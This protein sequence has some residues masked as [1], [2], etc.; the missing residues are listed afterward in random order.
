MGIAGVPP[1]LRTIITVPVILA[2]P[3]TRGD[4]T[5]GWFLHARHQFASAPCASSMFGILSALR[6]AIARPV[7]SQRQC[8]VVDVHASLPISTGCH[9]FGGVRSASTRAPSGTRSSASTSGPF[10]LAVTRQASRSIASRR[11]RQAFPQSLP[12]SQRRAR[13]QGTANRRRCWRP[14]D[15]LRRGLA[16]QHQTLSYSSWRRHQMPV[17]FRPLGARSSHWYMPQ[18]PSSPRA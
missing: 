1:I 12:S 17:S 2:R 9:G 7:G 15:R 5:P 18:R 3:A 13:P 8:F 14:H 11:R 10:R 6:F 16:R 4:D